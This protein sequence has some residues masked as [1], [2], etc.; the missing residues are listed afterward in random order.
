MLSIPGRI[1]HFTT[2]S[3][4]LSG[5]LQILIENALKKAL[6]I[7]PLPVRG[8]LRSKSATGHYFAMSLQKD[9]AT[10]SYFLLAPLTFSPCL[11][12]NGRIDLLETRSLGCMTFRLPRTNQMW[13]GGS[14]ELRMTEG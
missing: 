14:T 9:F 13:N 12:A 10:P 5:L 3:G 4:I 11:D 6:L 8:F 7:I 1:G 2:P